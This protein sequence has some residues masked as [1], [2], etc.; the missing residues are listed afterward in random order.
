MH[1]HLERA[2]SAI[3]TLA[4]V[5]VAAGVAKR[6]FAAP[7][8]AAA[9]STASMA[10][11]Y[12]KHW[13]EALPVGIAIGESSA[14]V[15]VV[16]F[17]DLECPACRSF[18]RALDATMRE[19]GTDVSTLFVHYPLGQ[20]HFAMA[21]ARAVECAAEHG[22]FAELVRV[23]FEKQDSIGLKPWGGYAREAGI[24]DTSRIVKCAA[25][26]ERVDRIEAGIAYGKKLGVQFT[27]TIIVN[28][29]RLRTTP[30]RVEL[31]R[32]V[33]ALVDGKAPFDTLAQVG[34]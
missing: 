26:S 8:A 25:S 15:T 14:R 5:V 17:S 6:E 28:G 29:W 12:L 7:D 11:L 10:P 20:H 18:H 9:A 22:Q 24:S 23:I 21:A 27:P 30:S 1:D 34:R 3:L 2:L 32:I 19:H 33:K 16:E 31:E 13:R 4:A